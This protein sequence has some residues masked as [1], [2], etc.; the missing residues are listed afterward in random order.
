[1]FDDRAHTEI[2]KAEY[3]QTQRALEKLEQA[4]TGNRMTKAM[5]LSRRERLV[6]NLDRVVS[7][8]TPLFTNPEGFYGRNELNLSPRPIGYQQALDAAQDLDGNARK[9]NESKIRSAAISNAL[10]EE[11]DTASIMDALQA[12]ASP[13][14]FASALSAVDD[15]QS[16]KL[17][18]A[19][20]AGV[21]SDISNSSAITNA[22]S[23]LR[24][25]VRSRV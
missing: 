8:N 14:N 6:K 2:T 10:V 7:A 23:N 3:A 20:M 5:Y 19:T 17:L 13:N 4:Y 18:G 9:V 16:S 12:N 1:M 11:V 24:N 15:M 21:W 22:L 25:A